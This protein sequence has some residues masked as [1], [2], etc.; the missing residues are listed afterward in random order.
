MHTHKSMLTLTI[1][2]LLQ[3]T[4]PSPALLDEV[5]SYSLAGGSSG[6]AGVGGSS[7]A[8]GVAGVGAGAGA[9]VYSPLIVS[10]YFFNT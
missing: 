5:C 3:V 2:A 4:Q 9:V 6:A 7:G 1:T 10:A 8:A